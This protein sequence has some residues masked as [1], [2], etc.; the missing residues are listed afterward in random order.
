MLPEFEPT[1]R[2]VIEARVGSGGMGD[3]YRG[4]D[5]ETNEVVAIKL[6]RATASPSERTRFAR[7]IAIL[8]DLRH[9]NIVQ[10][11]G[12]GT[13]QDGRL[14]FA[15]EWLE[16]EDLGQRQRR[17]PLGMRDSVEI[18]RRSAAAMAAIHARGVIHRDLKLSNI[19]LI[20]G[21]GTAIK[22]IDFGVVKPAI[23]DDYP[24]ERGQIIGTPHFMAPEQARGEGIDVRADVY[25]LG[26]VLF[27]LITGRN[28]FETEHIIALLG[29]LVLEDPPTAG[30][31]RFDVPEALDQVITRSI[32]RDKNGRFDN[33][34]ELA[35]ALARVGNLNNDPP[36]TDKSA[37][38]IRKSMP[39]SG[40]TPISAS[41]PGATPIP[42]RPGTSERR[43]VA[44]VLYDL[45]GAELTPEV[46]ASVRDV[47]GDDTRFEA[48]AGGR[49]VAVLGVERSKGDEA[50][51]AARAGL[52]VANAIPSAR[53]TVAVGH[54]VR[55]R[56]N[57]AGEA[58]ERAARQLE[59]AHPGAVRLDTYAAAAIEGRFV[60]QE[61]SEGGVLLRED[62]SG[63][64]A[65]QLL[66]RVTPTVGREKEIALLQGIFT[67]LVEDGTP[68][69]ALVTGPAGIGKSRVRSE[70]MQRLELSP[71]RPEML[72]CRGDPMSRGGSLSA[73]GRALRALMGVHDGDPAQDQINKVRAHVSAR[74]PRG[75]R[76]LAAFIG[77][78]IGVHWITIA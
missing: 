13:W 63:F 18:V 76:F 75:L 61:D 53:V 69:A 32:A 56:A 51:R 37:S 71:R 58:L 19:F 8:A 42:S 77:E 30:S 5:R 45:G 64:G 50:M 17:A 68:R 9:P 44:V 21:R 36:A 20:R 16:G 73:L 3:I 7:E 35:R 22:L 34:G 70:L 60:V 11:V 40:R 74:L 47:L 10:Y 12:H 28:V 33:G 26:S 1:D 65:R 25:S 62:A 52:A 49:M 38:A 66:G 48:L 72:L 4:V 43:V 29:R 14:F 57:L 39:D 27:R 55:G 41:D 54:A 78:L 2:F 46:D 67:E 59:I 24:T 15:M 23:P 6:L 31:L